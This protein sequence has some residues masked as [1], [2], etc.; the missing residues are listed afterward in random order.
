MT[1]SCFISGHVL[2]LYFIF[3]KHWPAWEKLYM[4]HCIPSLAFLFLLFPL[5]TYIHSSKFFVNTRLLLGSLS[6]FL[7]HIIPSYS[8]FHFVLKLLI[9]VTLPL[10]KSPG[11]RGFFK[12]NFV[13]LV[14]STTTHSSINGAIIVSLINKVSIS[15][16]LSSP[17]RDP[18]QN[19]DLLE[20]GKIGCMRKI[21][22][23]NNSI[24]IDTYMH[25]YIHIHTETYTHRF[26]MKY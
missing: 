15:H 7:S 6:Q 9:C 19:S 22:D 5:L 17:S 10:Y 4:P 16:L 20:V 24:N 3:K 26:Q 2:S 14:S 21:Q 12:F 8:T 13:F 25:L 23:Y 18:R 1:V 11:E